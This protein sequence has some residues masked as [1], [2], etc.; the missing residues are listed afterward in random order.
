[1]HTEQHQDKAED[2]LLAVTKEQT[3]EGAP[4][5]VVWRNGA[6]VDEQNSEAAALAV[7]RSIL[8]GG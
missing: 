7:A 4:V 2:I 8:A 3:K 1:M 5:W 6:V